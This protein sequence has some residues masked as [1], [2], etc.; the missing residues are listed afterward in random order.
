MASH[1]EMSPTGPYLFG[2]YGRAVVNDSS[3]E[4]TCF[5][6]VLYRANFATEEMD[7]VICNLQYIPGALCDRG[8]KHLVLVFCLHRRH[9]TSKHVLK[10]PLDNGWSNHTL[11]KMSFTFLGRL[12][13]AISVS[14]KKS[15]ILSLL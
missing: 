8:F 4:F 6:S 9:L 2:L 12:K 7:A 3:V 11:L 14:L 5:T 10:P 15:A 13:A 1:I